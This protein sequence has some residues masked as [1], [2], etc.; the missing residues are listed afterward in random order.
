[1][2]APFVG[3]DISHSRYKTKKNT[4]PIKTGSQLARTLKEGQGIHG[5]ARKKTGET[6]TPKK[7]K[8]TI[9]LPY[10]LK[11]ESSPTKEN[12]YAPQPMRVY[13]KEHFPKTTG[14]V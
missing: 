1:L 6:I 4:M 10:R 12:Y 13:G 5:Y 3:I 7:I 9:T 2:N 8:Q 11:P 14:W